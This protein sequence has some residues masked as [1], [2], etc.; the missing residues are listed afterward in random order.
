MTRSSCPD[1]GSALARAASFCGICGRSTGTRAERRR[2]LYRFLAGAMMALSLVAV[3]AAGLRVARV[4]ADHERRGDDETAVAFVEVPDDASPGAGS[5]AHETAVVTEK[6][7]LLNTR[8][9]QA[10]MARTY[11]P[12]LRDAGVSGQTHV[13]L[14]ITAEGTVEPG[15]VEI[16]E[17]S[18]P[19]FSEATEH[20]VRVM[21]FRPAQAGGTNVA[22][23]AIFPVTWQTAQ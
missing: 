11:P 13:K 22:A 3:V 4:Q 21:R 18:H 9:V 10:V 23:W 6:P 5:E 7:A 12:L 20:V 15:S 14:R 17:A 2:G 1:C 19:A 16:L 8:E